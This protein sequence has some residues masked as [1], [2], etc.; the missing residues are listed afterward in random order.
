MQTGGLG[1][2]HPRAGLWVGNAE[3]THVNQPLSANATNPVPTS[4]PFQFRILVHVNGNGEAKLLQEVLQMWNPGTYRTNESGN[5][6][7]D[8]PGRFVLVTDDHL[9]PSFSGA[10][11]RDGEPVAR[12][13]S[14]AAFAFRTPIAMSRR[15]EFG[16]NGGEYSCNVVLSFDD[17][18]NPF[19]HAYHP[20]HDNLDARFAQKLPE[21]RES[22]TVS[23][24]LQIQFT[25]TDP[26]NLGLAGWGDTQLGGVYQETIVGLHKNPLYLRGTV[27]LHQAS[28]VAVLNQ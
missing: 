1:G 22:F 8:Q 4:A 7:V 20:D 5:T 3:I 18:L 21:G 27:R 6:E 17:P 24:Q 23:R 16:G 14:T 26:A 9:I 10:A 12:R 25:E 11:L 13:F 2:P 19:Q 28:R 15:G